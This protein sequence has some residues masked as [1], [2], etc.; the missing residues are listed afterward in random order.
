MSKLVVFCGGMMRGQPE[1]WRLE[2]ASF[3]ETVHTAPHYRLYS[4][5][6]RYPALLRDEVNGVAIVGEL[7][8]VPDAVWKRVQHNLPPGI[9]HGPIMIDDG[10]MLE[11]EIGEIALVAQYGVDISDYGSWPA[12]LATLQQQE[13]NS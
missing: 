10:R 13:F 1:H 8:I 11:G 12:Y 3:L 5:G 9:G 7:F 4:I 6:D 2:G